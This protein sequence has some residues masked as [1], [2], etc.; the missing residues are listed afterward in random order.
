MSLTT[1]SIL[2]EI[3]HPDIHL[4]GLRIVEPG[5]SITDVVVAILCFVLFYKLYKSGK[6]TNKHKF[7]QYFFLLMGIATFIGGTFGHAFTYAVGLGFKLPGWVISMFAVMIFERAS[8]EQAASIVKKSTAKAFRII[9]IVELIIFMALSMITINFLFVQIHMFYG[10]LIVV[11]SFQLY[12]FR[13]TKNEGSKWMLI[14]IGVAAIAAIIFNLQ[15]S[16]GS[17]FNFIVIS[18][19]LMGVCGILFYRAAIKME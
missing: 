10:F 5:A 6:N 9:N 4:F 12:I 18:H 13:R 14:S 8:I 17:F 19:L 16:I 11:F 7:F 15:L 2:K 3:Y 1:I